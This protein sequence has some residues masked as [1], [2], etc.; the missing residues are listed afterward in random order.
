MDD[1]GVPERDLR[2]LEVPAIGRLLKTG[3]PWEPYCLEYGLGRRVEPAQV[4]L[5][6]LLAAG[7]PPSTLRSYGH[8]LL[9]WWRFL[10]AIGVADWDRAVREDARDFML[11]MPRSCSVTSP[12]R[13]CSVRCP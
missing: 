13:R 5:Q 2:R 11:W 10:A 8:D 7:R 9:R 3:D 4:F 6:D 1:T 12:P